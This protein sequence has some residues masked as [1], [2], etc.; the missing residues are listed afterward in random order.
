MFVYKVRAV[1][2][3]TSR[4]HKKKYQQKNNNESKIFV[5]FR[6]VVNV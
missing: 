6:Q 3:K 2:T 4:E 5:F 1:E